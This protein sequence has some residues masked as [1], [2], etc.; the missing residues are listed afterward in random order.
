MGLT[1]GVEHKIRLDD[2]IVFAKTLEEH[3]E[4]MLKVLDQLGEVGLKLKISARFA[5]QK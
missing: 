5:C 3:E 2:L 1:K 4:R